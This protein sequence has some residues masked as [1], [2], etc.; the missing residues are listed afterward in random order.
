MEVFE[1]PAD[2]YVAGFIGAPAMNFLPG[3]LTEGGTAVR[4]QAGPVI[5][6]ATGKPAGPDGHE[7]T[8]GIRP[9][10]V[11]I[12]PAS[13]GHASTG[14][15]S[16]DPAATGPAS[17]GAASVTHV[18]PGIDPPSAGRAE[19]KSLILH[20]DLVE[21]LG[22]ETLVHGRLA[23]FPTQEMV[24]RTPGHAPAG[25]RLALSL[26]AEH[27]HLFDRASGRRMPSS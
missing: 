18:A 23:G 16:T 20:V 6:L 24:V 7:V 15:A 3:E 17:A 9:E 25:E 13:I 1:R 2:T 11:A 10:H 12:E 4:L 22:S 27:L 26:M 8:I 19:A 14:P 21:P 5:P